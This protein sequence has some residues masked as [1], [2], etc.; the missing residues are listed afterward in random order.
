MSYN[1]DQTLSD[2]YCKDRKIGL[3]KYQYSDGFDTYTFS[4][5][6]GYGERIVEIRTE[7]LLSSSDALL[8]ALYR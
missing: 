6:T 2:D 7:E 3:F 8:T 4:M 5:K 1:S